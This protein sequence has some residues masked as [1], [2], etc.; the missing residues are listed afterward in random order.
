MPVQ[1][2]IFIDPPVVRPYKHGLFDVAT[3]LKPEA[4]AGRETMP[5]NWEY[6]GVEWESLA[7]YRSAQYPGGLNDV[8]G[9]GGAKT[10]PACMG[11]TQANAFAVYGGVKSGS[12]GH[13][14]ND[15]AYWVER[16]RRI[17]ELNAQYSVENALWTGAAGSG[18]GLNAAGTPKVVTGQGT[19]TD[20]AVDLVYGL[21]AASV[22]LAQNYAGR[23]VIHAPRNIAAYA[24]YLQLLKEDTDR[25]GRWETPSGMKWCFGGGYDGSGPGAAAA[26]GVTYTGQLNAPT[27][28]AGT[29]VGTGGTFAAA[30]Y[31]WKVTA[32]DASGE[33]VGSN[34]ITNAVGLNGSENLT[35]N[36]VPG[37]AGYRIYRG[38]ATN[39]ELFVAQVPRTQLA[40]TDTGVVASG[41]I[42]T[43]NTTGTQM[44]AQQQYTWMYVTGEVFTISGDIETPATFGQ[45]LDRAGNQVSLLAEQPWLAAV[46]CAKAAILVRTPSIT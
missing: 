43:V 12:L 6:G 30:T 40:Y 42:P 35:W 27:G 11:V 41:A 32:I 4:T 14:Q 18:N 21:A 1:P 46:D 33:T 16:A 15:N 17:V 38:T 7:C 13:N 28:L 44:I 25:P 45:A 24:A 31:F 23:G 10:L 22:W 36:G 3:P 19:T 20:Q 9:A 5:S 26:P 2:Y 34:E 29:P 37:A 8:N 39:A